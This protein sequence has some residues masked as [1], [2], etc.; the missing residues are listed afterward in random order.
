MD[1]QN[2]ASSYSYS[3]AHGMNDYDRLCII[4]VEFI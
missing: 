4:I 2:N 3:F 1:L